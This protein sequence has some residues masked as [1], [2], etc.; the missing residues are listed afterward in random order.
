VNVTIINRKKSVKT[1]KKESKEGK[2]TTQ[3]KAGRWDS[4]GS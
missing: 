4:F 1:A 2:K 3:M